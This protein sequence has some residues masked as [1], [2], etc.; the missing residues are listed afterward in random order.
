MLLCT[1]APAKEAQPLSYVRFPSFLLFGSNCS[2]STSSLSLLCT[3]AEELETAGL[4]WLI[5]LLRTQLGT[6]GIDC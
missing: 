4:G 6:S 3:V 1:V 2:M 5:D